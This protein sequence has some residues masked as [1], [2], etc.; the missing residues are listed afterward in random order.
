MERAVKL[1][2]P[3][4]VMGVIVPLSIIST[5]RMKDLRRFLKNNCTDIYISNFGDRPGT[6]FNGVHQKVSIVIARVGKDK[7]SKLYTTSYYH[8]YKDERMYLFDKLKYI[9]NSNEQDDYCFKVGSKLELSIIEK[10]KKYNKSLLDLIDK[11][12]NYNAYLN[13]RLTFWVKSFYQAKFSSEF[14]KYSF[15]DPY[16][17]K[18]F[19]AITNSSLYYFIWECISDGW[20]ITNKELQGFKFDYEYLSFGMAMDICRLV[21]ELEYDLENNKVYIGSKQTEYEY[22][23]KKSKLLI[24]KI[25][26]ILAVYYNFT[27]EELCYIKNYQLKYR[28]NDELV[29]YLSIVL[30]I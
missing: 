10:M 20:H 12:G 21:D 23:H 7:N 26:E 27:P 17:A 16:L 30:S 3:K 24:D 19:V 2:K 15:N 8:W 25:D 5:P 28:M 6:L 14:K 18:I 1:L 29:N 22:R 13:T 4:G 11:N 9:E